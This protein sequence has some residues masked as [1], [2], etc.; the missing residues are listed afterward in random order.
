MYKVEGPVVVLVMY[1]PIS[2][3]LMGFPYNFPIITA[4]AKAHLSMNLSVFIQ[5]MGVT[6]LAVMLVLL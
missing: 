2:A 3:D 1:F 4:I 6:T 5:Y